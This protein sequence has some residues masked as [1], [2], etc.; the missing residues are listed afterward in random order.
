MRP[1]DFADDRL[2]DATPTT[3][4]TEP[5]PLRVSHIAVPRHLARSSAGAQ[6]GEHLAGARSLF[7][8]GSV[9]HLEGIEA[10]GVADGEADSSAKRIASDIS[11]SAVRLAVTAATPVLALFG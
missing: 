6:V 9:D 8:E 10:R 4:Q 5:P 7:A 2:R 11:Y 3:T 1:T